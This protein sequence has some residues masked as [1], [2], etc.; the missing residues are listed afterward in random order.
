[1]NRKADLLIVEDNEDYLEFVK[2]AVSKINKDLVLDY[3]ADGKDAI[4]YFEKNAAQ[5]DSPA[6]LV[7]MDVNLPGMNGIQVL[8][9]M[10]TIPQL[11]YIPVIMFSSSNNVNDVKRSYDCGANGYVV[12]PLGLSPLTE[13]LQS[14]VDFW[15][16]RNYFYN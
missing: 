8:K 13:T 9:R 14:I 2:R 1:M 16:G 11:R 15:L 4:D 7:I 3:V 5:A 10:R 6:K 12:K